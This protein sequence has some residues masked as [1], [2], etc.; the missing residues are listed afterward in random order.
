MSNKC[1]KNLLTNEQM[2]DKIK[3]KNGCS[4]FGQQ[5]LKPAVV[6]PKGV[7]FHESIP[8]EKQKKIFDVFVFTVYVNCINNWLGFISRQECKKGI[9]SNNR[10]TGRYSL[11]HS[12]QIPW[13]NR[14]P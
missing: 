7:L 4:F 11:G 12:R 13:K 8:P 14:N 9:Q 1:S 5:N 2:F 6:L 10:K 3:I